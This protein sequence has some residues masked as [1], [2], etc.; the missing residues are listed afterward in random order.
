MRYF[1]ILIVI[2]CEISS[3]NNVRLYGNS[4][5]DQFCVNRYYS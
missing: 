2:W 4:K 1:L 3:V 5:F